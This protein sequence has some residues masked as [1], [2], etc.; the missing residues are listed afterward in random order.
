MRHRTLTFIVL[1]V[2]AIGVISWIS[3][4]LRAPSPPEHSTGE[5]TIADAVRAIGAGTATSPI[6]GEQPRRGK[7]SLTFVAKADGAVP[8]RIVSDATG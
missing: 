8:P 6:V 7:P 4:H 2:A 5:M 1:C 3:G